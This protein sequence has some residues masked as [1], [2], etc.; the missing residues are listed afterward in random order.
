MTRAVVLANIR[1]RV[2]TLR[3]ERPRS[4][5]TATKETP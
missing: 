4:A 3:L 5:A 1:G 2:V